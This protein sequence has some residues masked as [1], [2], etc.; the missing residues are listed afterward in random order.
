MFQSFQPSFFS[1]PAGVFLCLERMEM[2]G[3]PRI[4][5]DPSGCELGTLA[6]C[7]KGSKAGP[8]ILSVF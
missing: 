5:Y 3:T 6:G 8:P 4:S 2:E 1:K 7:L